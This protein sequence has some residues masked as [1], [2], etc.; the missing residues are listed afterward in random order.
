MDDP[1]NRALGR[2]SRDQVVTRRESL[3]TSLQAMEVTNGET[4]D[5]LL[6]AGAEQC[7]RRNASVEDVFAA[8]LGRLP[9]PQ[10]RESAS[11]LTG[12]PATVDGY[13]DLLW[14]IV[15]L[16]EFQLIY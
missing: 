4:L 13:A 14:T 5:R 3:A 16:P 1:L 6:R 10:E 15:M 12:D 7:L 9:T 2:P 8:A 11:Q